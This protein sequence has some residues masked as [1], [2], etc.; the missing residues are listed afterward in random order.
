M[1]K[2][3]PTILLILLFT[4]SACSKSIPTPK[5]PSYWPTQ[6]WQAS[7]P[8]EQGFDS[9]KLAEGL[10]EIRDRDIKIHSLTIIRSGDLILDANL[11]PYDGETVHHLA[12]VTKSVMTTLIAIAT[13]QGYLQLDDH[14]L[15][16]FPDREIANNG[17]LKRFITVRHLT[18]MSS[19]LDCIAA[20]DEQTLTEMGSATDWVQFTLDLKVTHLPGTHFEYCSPGMHVL[21]A[22]L[23]EATGMTTAEFARLNLFEPLGIT[24]L[25]WEQD[26]QGYSDGWAGLYLYPRDMAKLGYLML[27]QGQWDG[28]QIVSSKWVQEATR[29]QSKTGQGDDYGYGWWVPPPTQFIEFAAEGRGGQYIRVL[30]ELDLIVVTTG[31]GFEWNDIVPYLV[32]AMVD[33]MEPLPDN[34]AGRSQLEAA[35]TEIQQLPTPHALHPLPETAR[36]ISGKTYAFEFSPLDLKTIRWDFDNSAQTHLFVTFYNQPDQ[37]LLVPMDGTYRAYPIGE[38]SLPL[39]VRGTWLDESTFLFE[40]DATANGE[41]Y[42]LELSFDGDR[43]TVNSK[44]RT[45]EAVLSVEGRVQNP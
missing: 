3:I 35:L 17:F 27:H 20:N 5:P 29:L 44:E 22:I 9:V 34:P 13:D 40:Y 30:P 8:E 39:S 26:P 23:Q 36:V 32:P 38:H 7:T 19:G 4:V 31:G 2:K 24:D 42:S 12:S 45:H 10:K 11:H 18:G 43:V 25:I 16:F 6:G 33:M 1:Y 28:K 37:D 41:G 21:S 15:S 14:M